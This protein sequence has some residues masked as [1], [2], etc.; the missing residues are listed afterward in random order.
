MAKARTVIG[1]LIVVWIAA[2]LMAVTNLSGR[3]LLAWCLWGA[4][5]VTVWWSLRIPER[6]AQNSEPERRPDHMP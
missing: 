2:S 6:D 5:F 3:A 4:I 1:S